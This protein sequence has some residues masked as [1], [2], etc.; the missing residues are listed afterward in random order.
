M[1]S[2][3]KP[4]NIRAIGTVLIPTAIAAIVVI[5]CIANLQIQARAFP[6]ANVDHSGYEMRVCL[7]RT[8]SSVSSRAGD[9][10]VATVTD[11][12]PFNLARISGHIESITQSQLFKG[13][14]EIQLRF[15]R[16]RFKDRMGYPI[17]A[18][19]IRLYDI[20]SSEQVDAEASIETRGHRLPQTLKRTGI[21]ALESGI[22]GVTSDAGTGAA[23]RPRVVSAGPPAAHGR[24]ELIL[25]HGVEM[26]LRVYPN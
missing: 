13:S 9:E 6:S 17:S 21:G 19:I 14:T 26:L 24:K 23:V 3:I 25:D 18:E 20:T 5:S 2:L 12:G 16:I 1:I 4:H 8:L 15:D 7:D 10:F 11:P 22:F